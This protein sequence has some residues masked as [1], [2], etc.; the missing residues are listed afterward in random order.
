MKFQPLVFSAFTLMIL[1]SCKPNVEQ[2][3]QA[4]FK[5]VY[6]EKNYKNPHSYKPVKTEIEAITYETRLKLDSAQSVSMIRV[7]TDTTNGVYKYY[8]SK[9]EIN[10]EIDSA[11]KV[12][13]EATK[14][15]ASLSVSEKK[16]IYYYRVKQ[17]AYENDSLENQVLGKFIFKYSLEADSGYSVIRIN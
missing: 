11:K 16:K 2:K 10:R 6:V 5:K 8:T 7:L 3:A 9:A 17:D 14:T 1:I 15:L 4:W 13:E 12:I